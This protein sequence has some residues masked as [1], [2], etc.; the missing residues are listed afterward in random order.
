MKS[1]SRL[2]IRK[3]VARINSVILT[4]AQMNSCFN[5]LLES[6]KTRRLTR[7]VQVIIVW[8]DF[9]YSY[10]SQ[11]PEPLLAN[12]GMARIRLY[13]QDINMMNLLNSK[14][15]TLQ[16]FIDLARQGGF[17]FEHLWDSGEAGLIEFSA[18]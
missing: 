3:S 7:F 6:P 8:K 14:E 12:Y 2:L 10:L 9:S 1:S 15:R 13:Q 11:V 4:L 17:K 18:A 16:E 5:M